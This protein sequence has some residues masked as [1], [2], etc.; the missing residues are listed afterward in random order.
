MAFKISAFGDEVA[1]D[2]ETQLDVL[3][4]ESIAYLELRG[5]WGKNVLDLTP[6]ELARA[7]MLLDARGFG[8]SAIASPIGKS[9]LAVPRAFE[10]RRLERA[11][12]IAEVFSTQF[13]RI[14]SFYVPIGGA[15]DAREEVLARLRLLA[16]QAA[17]MHVTLLHENEKD[18]YGDTAERCRD[19]LAAVDSP[20]LRLAFDPANF[21]Q[22][23]VPPMREAW[24]A[25]AAYTA[26]VHIKDARFRDGMVVPPGQG[27]A[28]ISALL[29]A[30]TRTGYQGFLT[31]EPH[32][33]YAGPT[34][35][36]SGPDGMRLASQSLR[37]LLGTAVSQPWTSSSS[38]AGEEGAHMK[39]TTE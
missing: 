28:E 39:G 36:F 9:S 2:L 12:A 38:S 26:H 8:V 24:P 21:V 35:G 31:L 23:G 17:Q 22:V 4:G 3:A 1:D 25:L 7:R 14:F 10:L 15:A 18:N 13:I 33:Q 37:V 11:V 20:A 34:S 27:D 32:L 5:A 29:A 30:L 6:D 19:L 16:N